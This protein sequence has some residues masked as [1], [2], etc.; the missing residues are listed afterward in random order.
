ME[1]LSHQVTHFSTLGFVLNLSYYCVCCKG[2]GHK[3]IGSKGRG[4]KV[5]GND[6]YCLPYS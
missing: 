1:L 6:E 3:V 4:H 5:I 2:R